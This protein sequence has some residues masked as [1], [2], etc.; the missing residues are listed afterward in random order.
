MPQR[1]SLQMWS[2]L[3]TVLAVLAVQATNLP[4]LPSNNTNSKLCAAIP[5]EIGDDNPEAFSL[6]D[7]NIFHETIGS[8]QAEIN[9]ICEKDQHAIQLLK[10]STNKVIFRM[11][12]GAT[13][14]LVYSDKGNLIIEFYGGTFDVSSFHQKV[15][16][17]LLGQKPI[18][19]D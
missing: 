19:E 13:E 5:V 7:I 18:L 3:I 1:F 10:N 14:P 15:N 8:L 6:Q 16:D 9:A 17:V 11:A 2:A 4:K 12:A